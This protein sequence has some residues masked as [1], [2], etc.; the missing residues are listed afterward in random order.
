M[1]IKKNVAISESGF[2]FNPTTGDSFSTN[3]IGLEIIRMLKEEKSKD[4]IR[5]TILGK[6]VTDESTFEKDYYDFVMML[7][8]NQVGDD[9]E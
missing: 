6:Y 9:S 1:K 2:I 7:A 3:P 5:K 8:N 4:D